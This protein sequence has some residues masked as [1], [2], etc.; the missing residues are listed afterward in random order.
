M[1]RGERGDVLSQRNY[2]YI[3]FNT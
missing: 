1:K 2:I 3:V